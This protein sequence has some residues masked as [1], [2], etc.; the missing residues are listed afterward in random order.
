MSDG[1]RGWTAPTAHAFI[2]QIGSTG[3]RAREH[4]HSAL[5]GYRGY[6]VEK[7]KQC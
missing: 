2:F 5:L 4:A 7:K 3:N 6:Q 1:K